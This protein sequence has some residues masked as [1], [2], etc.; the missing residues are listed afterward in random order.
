MVIL[1]FRTGRANH[2]RTAFVAALGIN[3]KRKQ[4]E[5]DTGRGNTVVIAILT[6]GDVVYLS[7]ALTP[8]L[9]WPSRV[10]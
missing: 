5:E 7:L 3:I 4:K 6:D 10:S 2:L 8:A 9:Y 1:E